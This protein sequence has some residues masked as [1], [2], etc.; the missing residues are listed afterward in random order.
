MGKFFPINN[1]KFTKFHLYS[2]FGLGLWLPELFIRF[3]Q[4]Q[5]LYPNSS[6]TVKQL[7]QL[8]QM[9]NQSCEPVFDVSVIQSTV[10]MALTSLFFNAFAGWMA[11]RVK[12]KTVPLFSMLLGGLSAGCIYWLRSSLQNLIISCI[13]QA[14]MVTANMT[15]G[16]IGVELFPTKVGGIAI[17][18]IM[19]SGRIGAICSNMVFGY[20]MDNYCEVPIFIVAGIVLLGTLLCCFVPEKK[21][22]TSSTTYSKDIEISVISH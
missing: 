19:C 4:Y 21:T 7:S 2:V 18:L 5:T 20:L 1:C 22:N 10:A 9:K 11:S 14:T 16:N 17:C 12:L 3:Q 8:P 13:F 6:V 15:I